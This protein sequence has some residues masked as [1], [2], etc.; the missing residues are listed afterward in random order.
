MDGF[1]EKWAGI[2]KWMKIPLYAILGVVGFAALG[3]L[4]G[5]LIQHLWNWLMPGVFGLKEIGFWQAVGLFVLARILF[6]ISGSRHDGNSRSKEKRK[7]KYGSESDDKDW[8]SWRHYDEWWEGEGK[9]AF[10]DY[11]ERMN[12]QPEDRAGKAE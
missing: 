8:E 7:K 12:S 6:G 3:F 2:P 1:K 10:R 11:A 9:K 4:F 5:W